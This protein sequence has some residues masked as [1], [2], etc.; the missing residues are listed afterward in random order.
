MEAGPSDPRFLLVLFAALLADQSPGLLPLYYSQPEANRALADT[1]LA[2]STAF[3]YTTQG[4]PMRAQLSIQCLPQSLH[5]RLEWAANNPTELAS[6]IPQNVRRQIH[7]A[8]M[9]RKPN[10]QF[11]DVEAAGAAVGLLLQHALVPDEAAVATLVSSAVRCGRADVLRPVYA[12]TGQL[13]AVAAPALVDLAVLRAQ[14]YVKRPRI[15]YDVLGSLVRGG[16]LH[17]A[18]EVARALRSRRMFHVLLA[19]WAAQGVRR[20]RGIVQIVSAALDTLDGRLLHSTHHL[21]I[22]SILNAQQDHEPSRVHAA[23]AVH[24]L[25]APRLESPALAA[26]NQL[27]RAAIREHMGVHAFSVYRDAE[28][29]PAWQRAWFG[30]GA[31]MATLGEFLARHE[32]VRSIMHLSTVVTRRHFLAAP[33]FYTAIVSGLCARPLPS[34]PHVLARRVQCAEAIVGSMRGARIACPPKALHAVMYAWAALG[35]ARRTERWFAQLKARDKGEAAWGIL[36]FAFV[37][38]R[39]TRGALDVLVRARDWLLANGGARASTATSHLVNMAMQV[40]VNSGDGHS[41]LALLDECLAR[42]TVSTGD[43]PATPGDPIT[44]TLI[45]RTLLASHRF[46]QAVRVYDDTLQ[47]YGMHETPAMLYPLFAHCLHSGDTRNALRI[48]QRIVRLGGSLR[49]QQ[50]SLMLQSLDAAG[51]DVLAA[52][53]MWCQQ[54]GVDGV[55][56][57]PEH[58]RQCPELI[59]HV[60]AALRHR[61]RPSDAAALLQ[62]SS[63]QHAPKPCVPMLAD[64]A[65]SSTTTTTAHTQSVRLYRGLLRE[66]RR[67]PVVEQRKKLLHNV[68]F[69]YELYRDMHLDD[70]KLSALQR[71]GQFQLQWLRSWHHK[72]V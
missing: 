3:Y 34:D 69:V 63:S 1:V 23:L 55:H 21:A 31:L 30:S 41:A 11:R 37:R 39:N 40:L 6:Y 32:D 52:Y 64:P 56:R 70:S 2:S 18:L 46:A 26:V 12:R 33:Q 35:Q 20:V 59:H 49:D 15:H 62:Q 68:R 44:L 51:D 43:L 60:C 4:N 5:K 17:G 65:P 72:Q 42:Y 38:R 58:A 66:V 10:A 67:F 8:W 24:R 54:H 71:D 28:S 57:V 50:W 19:M 45:I 22:V 47:Q 48:A 61:G 27:M 25:L 53:G 16:D 13:H 29:R 9:L 7:A 36:M 14:L